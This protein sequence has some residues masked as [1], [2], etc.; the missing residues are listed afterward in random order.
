MK[1]KSKVRLELRKDDSAWWKQLIEALKK[2]E[3]VTI[4][5]RGKPLVELKSEGW[6]FNRE[7]LYE[8]RLGKLD[9]LQ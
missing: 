6:K 4:C 1:T 8:E 2:G 9:R 5:R 7:E 3:M